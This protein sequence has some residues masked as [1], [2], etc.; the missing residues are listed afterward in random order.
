MSSNLIRIIA[1]S[2][3]G[4]L[5]L[6][7]ILQRVGIF[8]PKSEPG[9]ASGP[10]TAPPLPVSA[11]VVKPVSLTERLSVS[12]TVLPDESVEISSE[13]SGKVA[14]I[15]FQEG[16]FVKENQLLVKINDDELKAQLKQV[17]VR[18]DLAKQLEARRE[19]LLAGGGVSQEEFDEALTERE[20]LEAQAALLQVQIDKTE[21]RAPF[22]GYMSLREVSEGS[23]LT[24]GR[25][26]TTLVRTNPV[27]IE[28]AVPEKYGQILGPGTD[29]QFT[30][31]GVEGSYSGKVYARDPSIDLETRTLVLRA[32]S[33]NPGGKLLPGAFANIEV[34]LGTYP[35]ALMIPTEAVVPEREGQMVY[36]YT[37]GTVTPHRVTTGIRQAEQIQI[38]GG[39]EAGDT[40]LTTGLLQVRP[41]ATVTLSEVE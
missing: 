18:L 6:F 15:H 24:P 12:G 34:A 20:S 19:K 32:R 2:A 9:A 29:V 33:A 5:L 4:L 28:F 8:E 38:T 40:I 41:G 30:V 26:I 25:R 22:A 35:E 11:F 14:T 3:V 36:G 23:Y 37:G 16:S 17:E 39:L 7:L 31:E 13:V 21:I 1:F 10:S 27:K